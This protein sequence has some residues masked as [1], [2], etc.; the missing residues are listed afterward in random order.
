MRFA[1]RTRDPCVSSQKLW[2]LDHRGGRKLNNQIKK[3]FHEIYIS[4]LNKNK[5]KDISMKHEYWV[6]VVTEQGHSDVQGVGIK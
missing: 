3:L 4:V 5:Q 2:P 6:H 1:N